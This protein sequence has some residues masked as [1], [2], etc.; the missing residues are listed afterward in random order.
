M[1]WLLLH[2]ENLFKHIDIDPNNTHLL[3]GNAPVCMTMA[4][5]RHGAQLPCILLAI[6][7]QLIDSSCM[8][9]GVYLTSVA[10]FCLGS[11]EGVC[12]VRGEDQGRGR[13]RAVPGR[14]VPFSRRPLFRRGD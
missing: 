8:L 13:H 5:V 9:N 3:D 7:G 1:Q 14:Y 12:G 6:Y 10:F 2:T 4:H 11:G